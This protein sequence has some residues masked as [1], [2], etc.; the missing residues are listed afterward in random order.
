MGAFGDAFAAFA[1]PLI[2]QTDG[3]PEDLQKAFTLSQ[4]CY[5]TALL[6]PDKREEMFAEMKA[7]LGMEADE[8]E[9]FRRSLL[10]PMIARHK[11][12]F[13]RLHQRLREP[14]SAGGRSSWLESRPVASGPPTASP[15]KKSTIDRYAPC[16]CGSGKKY[17]FCCGAKAR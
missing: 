7:R 3:S 15:E 10:E 2:D 1:Q 13:P 6:P 17:K 14:S 8:F 16:P 12:M 11:A 9:D 4:L 5:N